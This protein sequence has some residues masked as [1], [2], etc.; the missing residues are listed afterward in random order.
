[1]TDRH[2]GSSIDLEK[3]L[4]ALFRSQNTNTN[5]STSAPATFLRVTVSV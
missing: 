5:G 4:V 2:D 1:M 3:E